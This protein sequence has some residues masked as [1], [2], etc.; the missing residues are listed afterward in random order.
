MIVA[1]IHYEYKSK[2]DLCKQAPL[3]TSFAGLSSDD[4]FYTQR[5]YQGLLNTNAPCTL[6]AVLS[7]TDWIEIL[8]ID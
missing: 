4:C 6:F 1:Y 2:I 3:S 5:M 7:S 8:R